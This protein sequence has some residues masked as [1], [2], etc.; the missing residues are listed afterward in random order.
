MHSVIATQYTQERIARAHA[1][2]LAN[3]ARQVRSRERGRRRALR[4]FRRPAVANGV[5]ARR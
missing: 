4:L 5:G 3:E 2:R 1:E